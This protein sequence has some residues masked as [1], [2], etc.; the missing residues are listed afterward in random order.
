MIKGHERYDE[1]K[2]AASNLLLVMS[3]ASVISFLK[4]AD[5]VNKAGA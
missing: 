4:Y 5:K 3:K 1:L 2:V